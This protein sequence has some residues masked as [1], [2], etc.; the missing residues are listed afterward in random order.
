MTGTCACGCGTPI[1]PNSRGRPRRYVHGHNAFRDP[2]D[3]WTFVVKTSCGCWIWIGALASF[4]PSTPLGYGRF[5][6]RQAHRV[7]WERLRGPVPENLELDHLCRM[8]PCVN[9]DHLEPVTHAENLRR[10]KGNQNAQKTHCI[11][12]HEFT[13]ENTY[14][15]SG[16]GRGCRICRREYIRQYMRART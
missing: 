1:G 2:E 15:Q 16:G 14:R 4:S 8:T 3:F 13:P 6:G 11:R 5:R 10:G 12:G 9:P 7:A